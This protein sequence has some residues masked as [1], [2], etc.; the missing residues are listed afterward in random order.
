MEWA[1]YLYH[2]RMQSPSESTLSLDRLPL[3]FRQRLSRFLTRAPSGSIHPIQQ[4]I[5]LPAVRL[6]SS[7]S[8]IASGYD[9]SSSSADQSVSNSPRRV[10]KVN[11][12]V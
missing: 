11:K 2:Q 8:R 6:I 7:G 4:A 12:S 5:Y 1:D 10:S 3:A 9:C